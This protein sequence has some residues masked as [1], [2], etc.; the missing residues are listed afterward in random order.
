MFAQRLEAGAELLQ[1]IGVSSIHQL[2]DVLFTE[3]LPKGPE[4]FFLTDIAAIDRVFN[5]FGPIKWIYWQHQQSA[6]EMLG[7]PLHL[8]KFFGPLKSQFRM[9]RQQLQCGQRFSPR[10]KA[11][12]SCPL[13][14]KR[15]QP[16]FPY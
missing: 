13:L 2:G 3:F 6:S 11:P 16:L 14:R 15:R 4:N 7:G 12:A 8:G 1:V 10:Y 5:K 9:Q